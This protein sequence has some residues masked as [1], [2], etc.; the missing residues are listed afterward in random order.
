VP[1]GEQLPQL[2]HEVGMLP[3]HSVEIDGSA[4][5]LLLQQC[6]EDDR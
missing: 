5:G 2:V 6:V 3:G 4:G 1:D